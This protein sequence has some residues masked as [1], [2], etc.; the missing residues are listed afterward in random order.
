VLL[1]ACAPPSHDLTPVAKR[2]DAVANAHDI[3][4]MKQLFTNDCM[5]HTPD[6]KMLTGKDSFASWMSDHMA[7]FHVTSRG[8]G[9]SGDTVRWISTVSSDAFAK[10]GMASVGFNTMAIFTG[11]KISHFMPVFD[12]QTR[13]KM[14]FGK[15]IEEVINGG[16]VDAID[17]YL[18]EDF[19][20]H[21]QLPPGTPAGREGVKTFFRMIHE[22]FPDLHATPVMLVADGDLVGAYQTWEGTNKGKFMGK[23]PTNKK[24]KFDVFD[25]IKVKNGKGTEHWG[26]DDQASM[27]RQLQGK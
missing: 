25:L 3:E 11:E 13:G 2:L 22:A 16:K 9:Q 18:S 23:A 10:M 24:V 4:G 27:M 7:G 14:M 8:F 17:E 19:V 12:D 1:A 5:V 20:E 15:F 21:Q 6:G 26:L